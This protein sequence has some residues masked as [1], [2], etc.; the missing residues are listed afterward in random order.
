LV[1]LANGRVD[2][3]IAILRGGEIGALAAPA[4]GGASKGA[5]E[6]SAVSPRIV[7]ASARHDANVVRGRLDAVVAQGR[8][9]AWRARRSRGSAGSK[10]QGGRG[11]KSGLDDEVHFGWV[12]D[13]V[14]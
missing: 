13:T 14:E 5:V 3:N 9:G 8:D 4:I 7:V 10:S 11:D 2:A 12:D 6:A 1:C